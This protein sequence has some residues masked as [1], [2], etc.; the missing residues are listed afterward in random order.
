LAFSNGVQETLDLGPVNDAVTGHDLLV[1][2]YDVEGV[3]LC[4]LKERAP[5]ASEGIALATLLGFDVGTGLA[6]VDR[7]TS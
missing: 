1:D 3:F 5:V 7:D 2:G 6:K 4:Q